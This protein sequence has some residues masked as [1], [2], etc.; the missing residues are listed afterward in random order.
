MINIYIFSFLI[1]VVDLTSLLINLNNSGIF[2]KKIISL[3]SWILI[4]PI[5]IEWIIT[6]GFFISFKI[7]IQ[8]LKIKIKKLI[9]DKKKYFKCYTKENSDR[10]YKSLK[11]QGRHFKNTKFKNLLKSI[12]LLL[13]PIIIKTAIF[14]N[15]GYKEIFSV[16]ASLFYGYNFIFDFIQL[17]IRRKKQCKYKDKLIL[18]SLNNPYISL[19]AFENNNHS[20]L[21]ENNENNNLSLDDIDINAND[22]AI[23]E[24]N[25][26]MRS[27]LGEVYLNISFMV[28][29]IILGVLFIIYF[30]TIGEKLDGNKNSCTWIVLFI[31]FYICILP[32][33]LFSILHIFSLRPIFKENIWKVVIT[34][35]PCL[36]TFIPNCVIIPLKLENRIN[37]NSYFITIFF[38]VG[39]IFFLLHLLVLNNKL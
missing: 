12:L 4:F 33:L 8:K 24:R 18:E 2:K 25:S 3:N 38:S 6:L 19:D 32:T 5:L 34:I 21:Q 17:I 39:T 16:T 10:L 11:L 14:K 37:I 13:F 7:R 15:V 28:I 36:L 23:Y 35:L 22:N 29:K 9:S 27:K 1:L 20:N 31:P 30:G 26:K